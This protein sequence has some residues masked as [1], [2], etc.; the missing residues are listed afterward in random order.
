MQLKVSGKEIKMK[1]IFKGI[2]I[3]KGVAEGEA[4]VSHGPLKFFP[5]MDDTTGTI[6]E[7]GHELHGKSVKDKVVFCACGCGPSYYGLFMLRQWGASP[8]AIV[9]MKPYHQLVEDAVVVGI[10]MVYGF[11]HN[12]LD[13]VENGDSVIID[14]EKGTITIK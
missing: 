11:D 7:P 3:N 5:P 1:K 12:I 13:M 8:K 14:S 6:Y 4:L 9:A 10:P 2:G